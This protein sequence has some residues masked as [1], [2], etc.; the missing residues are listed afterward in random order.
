MQIEFPYEGQVAITPALAGPLWPELVAISYDP[1]SY[2]TEGEAVF[3]VEATF[4]GSDLGGALDLEP[5][6]I[7]I[8]GE[9]IAP[10]LAEFLVEQFQRQC[11]DELNEHIDGYEDYSEMPYGLR[12]RNIASYVRT[13]RG[14]V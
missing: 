5:S 13:V 2:A 8:D 11:A 3:D 1:E 4:A 14:A 9:V 12:I 7:R 6:D 10:H